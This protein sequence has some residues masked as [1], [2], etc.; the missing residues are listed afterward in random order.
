M[1]LTRVRLWAGQCHR[2]SLNNRGKDFLIEQMQKEQIGF[3]NL[4]LD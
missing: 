4:L 2:A 3:F 1:S